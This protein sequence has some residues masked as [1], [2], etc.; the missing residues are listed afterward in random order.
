MRCKAASS[1]ALA[2]CSALLAAHP[3]LAQTPAK[4]GTI[5]VTLGTSVGW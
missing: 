4:T 2:A 5:L 1:I 3:G